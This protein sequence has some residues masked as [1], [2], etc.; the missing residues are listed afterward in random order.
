MRPLFP[1]WGLI[2]PR[3]AVDSVFSLLHQASPKTDLQRN[4][5]RPVLGFSYRGPLYIFQELTDLNMFRSRTVS[6]HLLSSVVLV[7]IALGVCPVQA[8]RRA[9][10]PRVP[11]EIVDA[12]SSGSGGVTTVSGVSNIPTL[13]PLR[14]MPSINAPAQPSAG[15]VING[16]FDTSVTSDP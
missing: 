11:T 1:L 3:F 16:V 14:R 8:Q 12:V 5:N 7:A 6:I 4:L 2:A 10:T 9:L 13:A 15:F